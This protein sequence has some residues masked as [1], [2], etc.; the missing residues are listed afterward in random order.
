[1]RYAQGEVYSL[2]LPHSVDHVEALGK[3]ALVVGSDGKD[4][5]FTSVRLARLPVTV[6]RYTQKN[7]AQGETRSHG[8]F[9]QPESEFDGLLGLPIIGGGDAAAGQLRRESAGVL[10]LRNHALSLGD[11]GRLDAR[12]A[13]KERNDGCR[14]SCV[15]WYGNSR[16]LFLRGRIFALMGYEIVEGKLDQ[17]R[18]VETRRIDFSPAP[19]LINR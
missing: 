3:H 17:Q 16:P 18:I 19:L 13:G 1:M 7:S 6:D 14:A 12:P 8:F 9:Y 2:P 11:L 15:D 10:F 5:H 4:L